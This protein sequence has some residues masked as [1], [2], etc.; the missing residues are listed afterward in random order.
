MM[1]AMCS[2]SLDGPNTDAASHVFSR[3]WPFLEG[4]YTYSNQS[5]VLFSGVS[6]L[7]NKIPKIII[8]S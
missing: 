3:C 4:R 5:K 6:G 7:P 1:H 8:V 2:P